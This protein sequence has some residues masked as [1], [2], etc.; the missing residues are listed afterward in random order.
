MKLKVKSIINKKGAPP[1]RIINIGGTT[2]V[3]GNITA[4]E[5]GDEIIV[6]DC[7]I[8]FPDSDMP[9]VDVVIPDF[10]YLLENRE[11]VKGL[12]ITH[13]HEDHFG[14]TPYLLKELN[15]PVYSSKLVLAFV[16]NRIED[17]G[18][19]QLAKAAKLI[20]LSPETG[21]QKIGNNFKINAF[22]MNHSVPDSMG[23]EIRTPQGLIVHISDFKVD[24]TPVLDKPLDLGR[25]AE[26]GKEGAL[27]LLSDCL[28]V[29]HAGYSE[30]EKTL[31][32]TFD[33]LFEQ[34]AERQILVTTISSNISRMH[35]IITS[36]IK[37]NRK[38]ALAGRSIRQ[39]VEIA[40]DLG[41]LPFDPNVFLTDREAKKY[42]SKD[43]VYI[44]AGCY[45]Q[46]NSSLAKAARKEHKNVRIEE[47]S[48]VIFSADPNPPGTLED[49]NKVQDQLTLAGAE[50]IYSEIQDNLHVSGH[51]TRGDIE[52]IAAAVHP[53]YFIPLGGTVTKMREYKNMIS[54]LGLGDD[55]VFEQLEGESVVFESG[56]AKKGD[57]INIKHVLAEGMNADQVQPIVVKDREILSNDGVFVVI[58]PRNKNGE[59]AG[60]VD[61]VTRG[62]VYMK[63]SKDLVGKTRNVI[64]NVLEKNKK[65][66]DWGFMKKRIEK[67]VEKFLRK[68]T[69]RHPMVIVHS[70]QV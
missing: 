65:N 20:E 37:H 34:A 15:I 28:G 53:K 24:W 40:T 16:K 12:I 18:T 69:S 68:Q 33:T 4:Y 48:M 54:D 35:Q 51:G 21:E 66:K 49:V 5:C 50:V 62:F 59:L 52:M 29:T 38:V 26:L 42:A 44:I 67:E 2:T 70:I 43:V 64:H 60:K 3:T 36:A 47:N 63:E 31:G 9:G 22:R 56:S 25:I 39:S 14:A 57:T 32:P 8:G 58:V 23:F 10:S 61:V 7:G 19:K 11:K 46:S 6:V 30:S 17:R 1:V 41:L 55:N 13:A 27:C 45:G